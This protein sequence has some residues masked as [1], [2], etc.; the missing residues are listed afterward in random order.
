MFPLLT[1]DAAILGG[2]PG[3]P[4][5]NLSPGVRVYLARFGTDANTAAVLPDSLFFHAVVTLHAPAYRAE[6]AG[7]LRQD[8][9]R[10]PLPADR[11]A[12]LASAALGRRVAALL[13][14]ETPVPGVTAGPLPEDLRHVAVLTKSGRAPLDPATDLAVTA[15]WGHFGQGGAVMPGRGRVQEV[16]YFTS[17][18][19]DL[20]RVQALRDDPAAR[21]TWDDDD[22][23]A[24]T[25]DV[26][27]NDAVHWAELPR[28]VWEFTLGEYPVLKKWFSYR[29]RNV[30]GRPLRPEEAR[31][32]TAIARRIA[33]LLA[34]GPDLDAAHRAT[35]VASA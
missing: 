22:T 8:W 35:A 1:R 29:E 12:L 4:R 19:V 17:E 24:R 16:A 11:D 23:P 15:G 33:A 34:L 18:A 20:R 13:D 27:L 5:P 26:F 10:I 9:P 7:A 25:L 2:T 14:P 30:L 21:L 31:E 28:A 3:E 32:F 6:N